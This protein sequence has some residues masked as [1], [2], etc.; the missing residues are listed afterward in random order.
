MTLFKDMKKAGIREDYIKK[1]NL[2]KMCSCGTSI[3]FRYNQDSKIC[4]SCGR[5]HYRTDNLEFRYTLSKLL[6]G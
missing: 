2:R 5:L 3:V 4:R 1:Y 6:K